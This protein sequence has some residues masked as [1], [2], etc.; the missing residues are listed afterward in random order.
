MKCSEFLSFRDFFSLETGEFIK[1]MFYLPFNYGNETPR[2]L[3]SLAKSL[4][5]H[6]DLRYAFDEK[7]HEADF[8]HIHN[9]SFF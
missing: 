1:F 4:Q 3:I 9:D 8:D 6:P 7:S 5:A 2:L